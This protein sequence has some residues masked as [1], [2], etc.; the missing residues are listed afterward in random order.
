MCVDV[1]SERVLK[2]RRYTRA[3][4]AE[5]NALQRSH[6]SHHRLS[7]AGSV[8]IAFRVERESDVA[9]TKMCYQTDK[10]E[11][12]LNITVQLSA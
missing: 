1:G 5:A 4:L 3:E 6:G 11:Q 10:Y 2:G 9:S 12:I 8:Y 7:P